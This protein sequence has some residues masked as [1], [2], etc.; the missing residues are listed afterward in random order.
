MSSNS[1]LPYVKR[2][3]HRVRSGKEISQTFDH[4]RELLTGLEQ[5]VVP[6]KLM[7]TNELS[8]ALE[9]FSVQTSLIGQVK[10]GKTAL[11]NA[12]LG[13]NALLPSDVNPWTSVVTSVH[14]NRT[15]PRNKRAIS[16]FFTE[17][18]WN[19][20]VE[21]GGRVAEMAKE[22]NLSRR[23]ASTD[24]GHAEAYGRT[25]GQELPDASGQPACVFELQPGPDQALCLPWRR[26]E[27]QGS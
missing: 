3:T 19:G 5:V 23:H 2:S 25:V 13:E 26:R 1:L 11:S 20:M 7:A 15:P 17:E 8:E 14:L 12:L 6:E 9:R 24:R 18:D 21:T 4:M 16:R 27:R 10:A 22:A